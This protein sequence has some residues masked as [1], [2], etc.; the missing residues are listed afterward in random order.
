MN[1]LKDYINRTGHFF[2]F[3]PKPLNIADMPEYSVFPFN[4]LIAR[5][6]VVNN[7]TVMASVIYEP[8][9]SS[10][11]NDY[12]GEELSMVYYNHDNHDYYLKMT[13][14][15]ASKKRVCKKYFKDKY[16]GETIGGDNWNNF[17][18]HVGLLGLANGETC[19]FEE[20]GNNA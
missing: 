6:T 2:S 17:F 4:V 5:Y 7:K 14:N 12:N 20:M 15:P 8:D 1:K 3:I 10:F 13:A 9:L 18:V 19:R 11:N 16:L